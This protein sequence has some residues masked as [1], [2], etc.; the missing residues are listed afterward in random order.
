MLFVG[1]VIPDV[2]RTP[3]VSLN[4]DLI[5]FKEK[6]NFL[7]PGSR[8]LSPLLSSVPNSFGIACINMLTPTSSS[9]IPRSKTPLKESI[10]SQNHSFTL[11]C[12]GL[13]GAFPKNSLMVSLA[14][15]HLLAYLSSRISHISSYLPK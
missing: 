1:L 15:T 13:G 5:C 6:A 12:V 2:L 8:A 4:T 3:I 9:D 14:N 11:S 7:L 10:W